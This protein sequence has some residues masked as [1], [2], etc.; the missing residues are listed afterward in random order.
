M[1]VLG[2]AYLLLLLLPFVLL[3]RNIRLLINNCFHAT[4]FGIYQQAIFDISYKLDFNPYLSIRNIKIF[5]D[6]FDPVVYLASIFVK[7]FGYNPVNLIVFEFL[8]LMLLISLV[9]ILAKREQW[10][11]YLVILLFSKGLLSAFLFP[12]HPTT[13]SVPISFL[14]VFGVGRFKDWQVFILALFLCFFREAI[15]FGILMM[16]VY[17]LAIGERKKLGTSFVLLSSLFLCFIFWGRPML[18]GE[19]IDYGGQLKDGLN[20][21]VIKNFNYKAFLKL[22][23]PYFLIYGILF[24]KYGKELIRTKYGLVLFYLAPFFGMHFLSNNFHFQYGALF[25]APFLAVFIEKNLSEELS[26]KFKWVVVLAF[27]VTGMGTWTKVF[28]ELY[29][30]DLKKCLVSTKKR[31]EVEI[32][33]KYLIEKAEDKTILATGGIVPMILSPNMLLYQA[34]IF[35]KKLDAYDYLVIE[36]YGSG[37]TFP[38]TKSEIEENQKKCQS[39]DVIISNNWF[40]LIKKPGPMCFKGFLK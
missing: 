1:R 19:T 13:W 34:G 35:S 30:D 23:I 2:K 24:K 32:L 31:E 28:K 3:F 15:P 14:L 11:F 33:K 40:V 6:H 7:V 26:K 9:F 10:S 25:A 20:L 12:I 8:W 37:D 39:E 29:R 22:F 27:V 4:D 16:G 17:F 36:K 5:N 21:G 18:W 38:F